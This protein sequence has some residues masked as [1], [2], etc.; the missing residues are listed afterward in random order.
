MWVLDDRGNAL[1]G[2]DLESG[3]LLAE[4]AL[5]SANDDPHGIFSDGVSVWVSDH[6]DK[7]LF[8]YRLHSLE[9]ADEAEAAEDDAPAEEDLAL[10]RVRDEEFTKLPRVGNNN[11][12]GLWSDG[13]VMYVAD[14]SDGKVYS[15]NMPD[16]IDA[17]LA[18]LT[19]SGV[20]IGEFDP[21]RPDYEA[22]VADGVTETTV[23]AEAAQDD[24]VVEIAPADADED[25]DGHQIAVGGGVEITVTVTSPD[26]SRTK[27]YHVRFGEAGPSA[28]CLRG[29]IGAGFS[30][31]VSGGGSIEDLAACAQSRRVT[32][33]HTL[34]GGAWVSY[35]L[36]APEFVNEAFREVYADGLPSLTPL[37][38]KSEGPPSAD[39]AASGE[40][41]EPWPECLRGAIVEG[42][43]L[44]LYEGGSVDDLDACAQSRAVAAL[45]SLACG[46]WVSYILGAPE[47]VNAAFRELY[48]DGLAPATP[49]LTRHDPPSS[50]TDAGQRAGN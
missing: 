9:Q 35:I 46:E 24:A 12:R 44:V 4:Y 1:F 48:P 13:D 28:N 20:D 43:S 47:F 50:D 21:G 19:L 23:E 30:L 37:I 17:R 7:R 2:Y 41:T 14:A 5:D 29:A 16:A 6:I 27:V 15:Y 45:Y 26:E 32:A 39:P 3:E 8:A 11:P 18:S 10:K 38:A 22:V 25:A 40:V 34:D 36:G 49:L 42:F 31:V 33:I